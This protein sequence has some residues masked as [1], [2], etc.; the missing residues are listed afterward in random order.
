MKV[1]VVV[2]MVWVAIATPA[3]YHH[4]YITDHFILQSDYSDLLIFSFSASGVNK[5]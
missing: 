4:L 2:K 3:F 5:H 1:I